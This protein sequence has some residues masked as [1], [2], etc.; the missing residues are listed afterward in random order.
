MEQRSLSSLLMLN[1]AL[2][3]ALPNSAQFDVEHCF[4]AVIQAVKECFISDAIALLLYQ[5][6]KLVP[7]AISG[8]MPDVLGRHFVIDKHPRLQAI[9]QSDKAVRFNANSE[10]PDPYDGLLIAQEGDIPVHACMGF[11]IK[12][13]EQLLGVITVDSLNA[14]TFEDYASSFLQMVN[15]ALSRHVSAILLT[16]DLLTK[17]Q[18]GSHLI[19]ELSKG[20]YEMV[21]QSLAMKQ[22]QR[23]IQLVAGSDFTTLITGET[24]T[25]KELVAHSLHNQSLRA[26]KVFVQVN[27]ASL[28][29]TLA[30]SELFGYRKGAFTGANSHRDGKFLLADGGT[31]FLDEIGELPLN[32]QSK[33]LRVLQSGEIQPVGADKTQSVDVRVIAATNR[34]LLE[35]VEAGRFR[36]D[37]YHRLSVFPII[38][39]SL[40]ER[41]DDIPLLTGFFAEKVSKQLGI[42]Q[43]KLSPSL[44]QL[45]QS[46]NWPG[47][48]RELE[49]VISRAALKAK[50]KQWPSSII[51]V[52]ESDCELFTVSQEHNN[53]TNSCSSFESTKAESF[54]QTSTDLSQIASLKSATEQFQKKLIEQALL[55]HELNWAAA[56]RTLKLDRANLVRLAK[57][58]GIAVKKT[59]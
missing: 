4:E 19:T 6:S 56:A 3:R 7:V 13:Q 14:G 40:N 46:Y 10:L 25:G 37:L 32:T 27:C 24:G 15:E 33:L 21:G 41:L 16:Q 34:N 51:S 2:A 53:S 38:V 36:A 9:S 43:L 42:A 44:Y 28:P 1:R 17:A 54:N 35:E 47:N 12:H 39:P 55:E 23:D 50:Q 8:L 18:Q 29:E 5:N 45:L 58:L 20:Q 49:H 57:R 48:I 26:S 11:P 59:I 52:D 22:L 31:I 30:E